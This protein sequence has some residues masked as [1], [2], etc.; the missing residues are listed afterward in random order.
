ME[1]ITRFLGR[2]L[3][4]KVN[5]Q[6]SSVGQPWELKFLG[7]SMTWEKNARLKVASQ[8]VARF[9]DKLRE[10]FQQGRGRNLQRV[11]EQLNPV[12]RGWVQYFRLAEVKNIFEELDGWIRRRLRKILWQQ[13]K[14]VYTIAKNLMKRGLNEVRAW[15]SATNGRGAWWNSGASHMN[16]AFPKSHFDRLGLMSLLH[17]RRNT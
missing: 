11:I 13:W 17:A 6:K 4:R 2:R 1:S 16:E 10:I 8:S 15:T 12:M 3:K 9:K 7:Y 5:A 14:R